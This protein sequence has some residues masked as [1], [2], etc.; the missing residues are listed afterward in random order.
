MNEKNSNKIPKK[1][2]GICLK[3]QL[4]GRALDLCKVISDDD[5]AS[6]HGV[7]KIIDVINKRDALSVVS[8]VYRDFNFL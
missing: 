2:R 7:Q 6:E 3:S 8:E 4:Y 5:I 1:L